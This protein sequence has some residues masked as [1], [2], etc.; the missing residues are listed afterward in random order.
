[1]TAALSLRITLLLFAQG[2]PMSGNKMAVRSGG[3]ALV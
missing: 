3:T 2:I 1:M